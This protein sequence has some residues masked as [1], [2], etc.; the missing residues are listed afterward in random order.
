MIAKRT[1]VSSK[2]QRKKC[3]ISA[4]RE[5]STPPPPLP[6]LDRQF[7][8]CLQ[9]LNHTNLTAHIKSRRCVC[10]RGEGSPFLHLKNKIM[11][12]RK[13]MLTRTD[14]AINFRSY[15]NIKPCKFEVVCFRI[16][17]VPTLGSIK[18]ILIL[19]KNQ[20]LQIQESMLPKEELSNS[21]LT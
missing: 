8:I 4:E 3:I 12:I 6:P 5:G 21:T 20:E 9:M 16:Q 19:K 14:W 13:C 11:Q 15:K 17:L 18:Q 2:G 10:G 1:R 7:Q